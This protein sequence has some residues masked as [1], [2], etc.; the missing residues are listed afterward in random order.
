MKTFALFTAALLG[1]APVVALAQGAPRP[2]A[3]AGL[4]LAQAEDRAVA[5][6]PDVAGAQAVVRENGAA[7]GA[8]R[9]SLGPSI[10]STYSQAPQGGAVGTITQHLTTV[11]VQTTVGD[12]LAYSPLVASAD[13]GLRGAQASLLA[14][15]RSERVKAIGLYYDALKAR[16]IAA[17]RDEALRTARQQRDAAQVRVSAGDAPR[18][19]LVRAN[20]AVARATASAETAHAADQNATE[21]LQ[22]ETAV[23][24][25]L[26]RTVDQPLPAAAPVAADAAV[27]QARANR[28]DLRAAALTTAAARAAA[29]A[30]HRQSI[31][32]LTLGAGYTSGV[33]SGVNVHGPSINVSLS[34]PLGGAA[35]QQALQKDAIV[36]EDLAKQRAAERQVALD[37]AASARNVAAA[38]RATA[39]TTEARSEAQ[40]ELQATELGYRNG[41]SSSLELASARDTY[42]QAV[43]DELSAVYDE[44]KARATLSLETGS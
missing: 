16:A 20:V 21:A 26:D 37:I 32:A 8:A 34:L 2:I 1:V 41:A 6:S 18:L 29:A 27:A 3:F 23:S 25:R 30:A 44:L 39:A 15:M 10:V 38:Q 9:A 31:P 35:R 24:G 11:G 43:V 19:D 4:S 7:L 17:A 22:V 5:E 42:T 40:T 33:D 28:A 13:A 14:A 12:L 36:A